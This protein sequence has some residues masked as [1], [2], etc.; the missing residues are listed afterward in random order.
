MRRGLIEFSL[1]PSFWESTC[2]RGDDLYSSI[3]RGGVGFD[4]D[5]VN[6]EGAL[7]GMLWKRG[8]AWVAGRNCERG[9]ILISVYI[10]QE[11]EWI[12]APYDTDTFKS[13]YISPDEAKLIAPNRGLESGQLREGEISP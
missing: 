13:Q 4:G 3:F 6:D 10:K 11:K 7:K 12:T 9:S 5:L 1:S 2:E 8:G